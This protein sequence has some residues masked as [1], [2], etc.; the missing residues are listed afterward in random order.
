MVSAD[1]KHKLCIVVFLEGVFCFSERK[2]TIDVA[3]VNG[4][5]GI[6]GCHVLFSARFRF[7]SVGVGIGRLSGRV[8][9][10]RF[11]ERR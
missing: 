9:C 1:R 5:G 6:H 10:T 11:L 2:S 4:C 3:E 8:G 7:I